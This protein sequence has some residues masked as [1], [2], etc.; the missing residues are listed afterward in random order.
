MSV[1]PV[2]LRGDAEALEIAWSD[3]VSHRLGWRL[4]RDRCPCATCRTATATPATKTELLPVLSLAEAQ[5]LK[6]RA[7]K[8]IGNYAFAIDFTDGHS[9]GI[10]TFEF[11]RQLGGADS[12]AR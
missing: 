7:V 12:G 9:T 4:L 5:P 8:P 3:G 10:F 6:G 2:S 11:L 1:H